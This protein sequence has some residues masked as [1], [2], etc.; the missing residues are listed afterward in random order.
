MDCT[1][2][3]VETLMP[4]SHKKKKCDDGSDFPS[5]TFDAIKKINIKV[6]FFLFLISAIIFSDVFIENILSAKYKEGD[7]PNNKG[8]I[9]QLICLV[10]GYIIIDLL[11]QTN[12][13]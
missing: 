11:S 1:S 3:D 6:A 7:T 8:T 5:M 2:D 4:N 9:I 12:I 13:L 10:V